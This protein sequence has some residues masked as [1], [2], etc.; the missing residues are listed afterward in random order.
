MHGL[1]QLHIAAIQGWI[2]RKVHA[3][4]PVT[5][6][7][8]PCAH[9]RCGEANGDRLARGG[10]WRGGHAR[11]S[12]IRFTI[13]HW[14]ACAGEIVIRKFKRV[15]LKELPRAATVTCPPVRAAH[16]RPDIR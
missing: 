15:R 13:S 4:V 14:N 5:L 3:V 9:I 6:S 1:R 7:R 12:K 11:D 10:R 2:S 16:W 8:V